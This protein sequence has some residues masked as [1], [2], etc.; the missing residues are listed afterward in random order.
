[1][2]KQF[3][4]PRLYTVEEAARLM[5]KST[6]YLYVVINQGLLKARLRRG[7]IRGYVITEQAILDF[8]ETGFEVK[9]VANANQ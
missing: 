7:T 3:E 2:T 5:K 4:I 8:Y 9:E 1:M 6:S